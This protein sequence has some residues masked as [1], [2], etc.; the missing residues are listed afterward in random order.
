MIPSNTPG[1]ADGGYTGKNG[2]D[3]VTGQLLGVV[4]S[5]ADQVEKMKNTPLKVNYDEF[6]KADDVMSNLKTLAK[7][8]N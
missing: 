4:L 8:G 5:L 2:T 3:A 6:S 1:Y 7:R